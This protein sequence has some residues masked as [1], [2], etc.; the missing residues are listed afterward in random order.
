MK[1][2]HGSQN[3]SG[4]CPNA[5]DIRRWQW[6]TFD[7]LR[8]CLRLS[9]RPCNFSAVL[10]PAQQ[11]G[12][13]IH[14]WDAVHHSPPCLHSDA[15]VHAYHNQVWGVLWLTVTTNICICLSRWDASCQHLQETKQI[16]EIL[17]VSNFIY[18]PVADSPLVSLSLLIQKSSH[19]WN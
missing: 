17:K 18:D 16:F 12:S 9:L 8:S 2:I 14:V 4:Q 13:F 19:R 6:M 1:R 5:G 7:I 10:C 3:T 15:A 11:S